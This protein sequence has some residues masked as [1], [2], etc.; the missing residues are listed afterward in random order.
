M[1]V[2]EEEAVHP[3]YRHEAARLVIDTGRSIVQVAREI[4]VGEALLGRRVSSTGSG[5]SG[6]SIPPPTF[7]Q[8]ISTYFERAVLGWRSSR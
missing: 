7:V 4:G 8:S 1:H 2:E 3:A 6:S 5:F